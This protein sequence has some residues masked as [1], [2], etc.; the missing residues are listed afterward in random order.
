MLMIIEESMIDDRYSQ[1]PLPFEKKL[2][3]IVGLVEKNQ[4]VICHALTSTDKTPRIAQAIIEDN[5]NQNVLIGFPR[6]K[7]CGWYAET[8]ASTFGCKIGEL[9]G[10]Y[11]EGEKPRL[12]R[13][14]RI[15]LVVFQTIVKMICD[16]KKLPEGLL[17][18]D[19][20]HLQHTSMDLI[21]GLLYMY[22]KQF[23][24]TKVIFLSTRIE[25][26]SRLF[27]NAPVLHLADPNFPINIEVVQQLSKEHNTSAIAR[28]ALNVIKRFMDQTL[29]VVGTNKPIK[30]GT[31]ILLIPGNEDIMQIINFLSAT[32]NQYGTRIKL[33]SRGQVKTHVFRKFA[34]EGTLRIV[35]DTERSSMT[36]P[37]IV[38]VIDSLFVKRK[39]IDLQG[40]QYYQKVPISQ[41]QMEQAKTIAGRYLK[42]GFYMPI[43]Y[44][45]RYARLG[46]KTIPPI[47]LESLEKIFLQIA[48]LDEAIRSFPFRNTPVSQKMD[49]TL[50]YLKD[51]GVL[52]DN[53]EITDLG[54]QLVQF[55]L[56]PQNAKILSVAHS[57]GIY[58][59]ALIIT[60][61]LESGNIFNSHQNKTNLINQE[62][63]K[64]LL[65]NLKLSENPVWATLQKDH[66][67]IQ[68]N[69]EDFIK[70]SG[71]V[72]VK[73]HQKKWAGDSQNDFV[74]ILKA[75]SAFREAKKTCTQNELEKWCQNNGLNYFI[76]LQAERKI[77]QINPNL[78]YVF[79]NVDETLLTKA[80][81][82]GLFDH[83]AVFKDGVYHSPYKNFQIHEDSS[84]LNETPIVLVGRFQKKHIRELQ[85]DYVADL[86]TPVKPEWILELFPDKCVVESRKIY[87]YNYEIHQ[88]FEEKKVVF[89][90]QKI[91][92]FSV[93]CQDDLMASKQF[94][95]WITQQSF[96]PN[97]P[98]SLVNS[99]WGEVLRKNHQIIQELAKEQM[100]SRVRLEK[101]FTKVLKNRRNLNEI[102]DSMIDLQHVSLL[103]RLLPESPL[104]ISI[105]GHKYEIEYPTIENRLERPQVIMKDNF[106]WPFL[107]TPSATSSEAKRMTLK[108]ILEDRSLFI[109]WNEFDILNLKSQNLKDLDLRGT[110]LNEGNLTK[111]D[112]RG[113]N[114]QNAQMEHTQL[115]E[116]KFDKSTQFATQKRAC[117]FDIH[118]YETNGDFIK[119]LDRIA[120]YSQDHPQIAY[121]RNCL[122]KQVK[123]Y[124][125]LQN[126]MSSLIKHPFMQLSI[127][128]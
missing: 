126:F 65:L 34:R 11:L 71:K 96:N 105:L 49:F 108:L 37:D 93:P 109:Q 26:L 43:S 10:L 66:W 31:V 54:K 128:S 104:Q 53:E 80:L 45:N 59:E 7:I 76:I 115:A 35:C 40:F 60:C 14:T 83:I 120:S 78:D 95:K 15:S 84:C 2:D 113:T 48:A 85:F 79:Q 124:Q 42:S 62:E 72:F 41:E 90:N 9:V 56:K 67:V 21:T 112:I 116:A 24:R 19:E 68:S 82:Y 121:I 97:L 1:P 20:V 32:T 119:A 3:E 107:F 122:H 89:Q 111:T 51:L 17:I 86:V 4:V 44:K 55:P 70:Q 63:Y 6:N 123:Y 61:F 30:K 117:F 27:K 110:I 52:N 22:L 38:G 77:S 106:D 91:A 13:E 50:E 29:Y 39:I 98:E 23:P 46:Q 25:E 16:Q 5:P 99:P 47:H 28:A 125:S 100:V 88:I 69:H 81:M 75:Y 58:V 94:A 87:F 92:T 8:L 36:W 33:Y 101:Y 64:Q 118:G 103:L 114:F 18:L 102:F 12:S 57:F 127:E 73:N 74:A